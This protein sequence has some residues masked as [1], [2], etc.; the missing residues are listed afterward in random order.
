MREL[1]AIF[2]S[3]I[4]I[5]DDELFLPSFRKVKK[6]IL[7]PS[8]KGFDSKNVYN[9][10]AFIEDNKVF[11]IYR[12]ESKDE[13]SSI[14]TGRLGLAYSEDG[15][16]FVKF[17][18]PIMILEYPYE[19]R[20]VE[21][22][23]IVKI[24][25]TYILTYTGYSKDEEW[26]DNTPRL[27]IATYTGKISDFLRAKEPHKL[28][29][30]LGPMFP[31]F[32]PATKSGAI[33]Q[34]PITTKYFKDSYLMIFGDTNL[35]LAYSKDLISWKYFDEPVITPREE[36]FDNLLVEGGPPLVLTKYGILVIYN[37]ADKPQNNTKFLH[38]K[39]RIGAFIIDINNPFKVICRTNEPLM[40]PEY[41]WE[42]NGYVDNV[43]FLEGMVAKDDK[44][45]A[46]YGAADRFI[47]LAF[48]P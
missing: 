16:N 1:S 7:G 4:K 24:D 31:D 47:S 14:C 41:E 40:E 12:A 11:L 38:N 2:E 37:S 6:I 25:Q 32:K 42:V 26:F 20:G 43:V 45:W 15:I 36:Y 34:Q 33:L 29:R 8:E 5:K 19:S 35:Y 28:W 22:P 44:V 30:K 21:D 18:E 13:D 3:V 9:C 46:Y 39:Y 17:P 10:A 48:L 23:R 27:C